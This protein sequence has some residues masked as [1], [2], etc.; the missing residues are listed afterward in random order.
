MATL[1]ERQNDGWNQG[2]SSLAVAYEMA[3]TGSSYHIGIALACS[4]LGYGYET[5][6]LMQAIARPEETDVPM[7]GNSVPEVT[8]DEKF[9]QAL[10]FSARSYTIILSRWGDLNTLPCVHVTMVF[11]HHMSRIPAAMVHIEGKFPWKLTALML[12]TLLQGESEMRIDQ[13]T[14]PGPQKN[15]QPRPLPEDHALNGLLY[16]QEYFP[17]NWFSDEK[18]DDDER[19]LEFASMMDDRRE[20]I[21]WLG[22]RLANLTRWLTWDEAQR[23]FGVAEKWDVELPGHTVVAEREEAVEDVKLGDVAAQGDPVT[24]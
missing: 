14:F 12:N 16:A 3:L 15:Q 1:A 5:N 17:S 24:V 18:T 20:R 23:K 4:L 7:S 10:D 8:P 9:E 6:V 22:R 11:L 13:E 21:L 19:Y 2:K